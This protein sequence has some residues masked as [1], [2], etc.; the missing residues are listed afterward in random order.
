MPGLYGALRRSLI[1]GTG[2]LT[3]IASPAFADDDYTVFIAG[4][5]RG[6]MTVRTDRTGLRESRFRFVDR[7]RGP[8]TTTRLRVDADGLPILLSV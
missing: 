7:G 8:E 3:L 1:A 6:E 5:E 4:Q 2:L